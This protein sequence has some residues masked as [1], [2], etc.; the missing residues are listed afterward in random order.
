MD[1]F[2]RINERFVPIHAIASID[3]QGDEMLVSLRDARQG[4]DTIRINGKGAE[5]LRRWLDEHTSIALESQSE[6][7]D[8][9]VRI[10]D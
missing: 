7:Q 3:D 2:I 5:Q 6:L 10:D 4:P 8:S 1:H 9:G